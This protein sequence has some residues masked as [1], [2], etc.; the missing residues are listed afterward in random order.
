MIIL[1]YTSRPAWDE[2][3]DSTFTYLSANTELHVGNMSGSQQK[4]YPYLDLNL[5]D[6]VT[7]QHPFRQ[8]QESQPA[9]G[10]LRAG[11]G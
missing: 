9:C 1:P 6:P 11:K 8:K 3:K 10:R 4:P 2:P 7:D 5:M